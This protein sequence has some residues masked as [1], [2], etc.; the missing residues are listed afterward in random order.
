MHPRI[1]ELLH[2]LD[3]ERGGLRAAVDD[4]PPNF[5]AIAPAPDRWS[6]LGIL[7]HLALVEARV[8]GAFK[9]RVAEGRAAGVGADTES[10]PVIPSMNLSRLLDRTKRLNAPEPIHPRLTQDLDAA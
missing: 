6:V 4:I 10:T 3:R 1:E 5:H 8:T 2:H 9:K 7:E